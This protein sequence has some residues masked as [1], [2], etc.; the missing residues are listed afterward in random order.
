MDKNSEYKRI[1]V[2]L[3]N[4]RKSFAG[5]PNSYDKRKYVWKLAYIQLLGHEIL[6]GHMEAIQLLSSPRYVEKAVGYIAVSILI[7]VDH[8]FATLVVNSMRSDMLAR[9]EAIKVNIFLQK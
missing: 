6:S 8:E 3:A 4:I 7:P 2:E 9:D 1:E 5:K